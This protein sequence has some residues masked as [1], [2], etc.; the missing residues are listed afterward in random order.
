M[1]P[2][3][4]P[5][6]ASESEPEDAI[7]VENPI[8]HEDETIPASDSDG[9]LPGLMRRDINSLFSRM[10]SLSRRLCGRETSH[11]FV[12]KKGKAKYEYYGKLILDLGNEVHSS[13]EQG[14]T[15]MEKL[16]EKLGNAEDKVECKKLKKEL[17]EARI[18]PPKSTPMT[19]ATICRMINGNVESAIAAER[20]RHA[21]VG[22]DVRGSGPARG[23]DAAP[24][25]H[26]GTFAGFMKCN[27]TAFREGK[28]V[29]FA[30]ATLQGPA[31]TW[32]NAK[33]ATIGLETVNQIPWTEMKKLMTAEFCPI[34]QIQRMEHELWNLKVKEYNIVAYTQRFN[35]LAL[36]C[37]RIVEQERVKVDAYIWGLTSRCTIKYHKCGKVGHKLRYYKEKNVVTGANALPILTCY[38]CGEQGH[39]RNRCP[40]KVKQEEVRE[41]HGR[42]YAIKDAEPKGLNV[43]TGTFLLNNRYAFVLF[44]SGSDRSFVDTRFSSM[45]DIDPVKIG[46]SYEVELADGRVV[47]TNTVLKGCTLNLV[48]HVFEID[49]MPIELGIFDV[50]IGMDWLVKHDAMI[51]CGEKVVRIPYGNKMLIVE[52]DKGV[53]RLKSKEKRMEDVPVICDFPKELPGLPPSRL[54]PS[55]MRALSVQ[56]QELLE[57]GLI[58]P[59]SSSWGAPVLFVKKKD[60]SFRMCIDY[61]ELNKLTVKNRYPLLRIDDLFDQLQGSSVYSKID[62]RSGYHQL[63]IK[64]EDIPITA[65]RNL[66]EEEHG[67]HLK[68]ILELL[69][70]ERLYAKFS[71]C[72]FGQDSGKE[73]EEAFQTLKQKLCSAPI[74]AFP[75]G[76]KDFVV[77]YDASLK[78]SNKMYQDLKPLY[79]WPNTK[80]D[81][82]TYWE[83]ITMDFVSGLPRTPSGYDTIWAIDDRL[84]KSAHFLP[85]KKTDSM[86]KLTQLYL[87]E[88]VCRHGVPVSIILDRDSHFTSRFLKSL[89]EALGTNLDISTAYYPQT[90]VQSKRTIQTLKDMLR[91]CVID[92][93]SSWDRHLP[94]VEFSYNNSYHTSFKAAPYEALYGQKCR[95]PVCWSEV[96]DS[97]LT[98]PELIRETAENIIQIKNR[99][100]T[101]RSRQKSYVDRRTKLLEFEV[102]DIVLLK[103]SPWK[104]AVHFGKRGKLSPRYIGPFRILARVGPVAYTLELPEELKGIH[105]TFHVLNLKK[106]LAEG[107]IVVSMDEIQFDDKLHMIEEPMEVVDREKVVRIPYGNKTLIVEGDKGGSRLKIILCIKALLGAAPVARAPYRLAPSEMK[108]LSDLNHGHYE[109]SNAV[110]IGLMRQYVYGLDETNSV[111]FLGHVIDRSG[112]HVDPA[113]IEATKSWAAPT[114]PMEVHEENYTTHDLE[115][116]AVVF[117]LRLW[118]HYLY[119]TKCV[120]FTNHNILRYNLNQKELNLRQRSWIELLSDYDCEIRYH[121][122]KANVV[123]DALSQKGREKP[124]RVRALMMT[125]HNDL[126]KQIRKAQGEAKKKKE[127]KSRKF[128]EID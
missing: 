111:Q 101:A 108:E 71:K 46:A 76:T 13:V 106:C 3:N 28:K 98:S 83:R 23:Q 22:N 81:I 41:V 33:V 11:A 125:V 34:E 84:T 35:E 121:P 17:E 87:K 97:Q 48:N 89:Q 38:D 49:L 109:S 29:R 127:C 51:V 25:A 44:D 52:S 26:E 21:N 67:K 126:P 92:F 104:G 120:V 14:T 24:A 16:V 94:L 110:W 79:L 40:R 70:E 82:A 102:G 114:T 10:T 95:S 32:W 63:R 15:A 45:L 54:A 50:I 58:R 113:K 112:V 122:R 6:P 43:V 78:G 75:E 12:E 73:E 128:G 18:M 8:E 105:S 93:G 59:S 55:E 66:D 69:K 119:G 85:M 60:G 42:A 5:P 116:G 103:V 91:A 124:L 64:E 27:P 36:M 123:A 37:P 65:F 80:V 118:R 117:A 115:L 86:E 99:L 9:L 72:D 4:P 56:L 47:S 53:S 20:A 31:L 68:I 2:F 30:A 107:D 19:Q 74:L 7:E 96:G 61:R 57:K 88:V 100:L 77:Y 1:D 62:L 39:T 90:D